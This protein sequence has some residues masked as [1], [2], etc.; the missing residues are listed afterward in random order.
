MSHS[1]SARH[2]MYEVTALLH[3]DS[4]LTD[5]EFWEYDN[6]GEFHE[7]RATD[8]DL[9][10]HRKLLSKLNDEIYEELMRGQRPDPM[11]L[12]KSKMED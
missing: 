12:S 8:I 11:Y 4:S 5:V 2:D 9:S 10:D 6:D 3:S 1:V 7:V